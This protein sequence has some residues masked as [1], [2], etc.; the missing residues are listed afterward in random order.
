MALRP[1]K[2][3]LKHGCVNLTREKYCDD[4]KQIEVDKRN[5]YDE[6]RGNRH[7]RGYGYRWSKYSKWYRQQNPLCVKCLAEGKL[8]SSEHV[9]HIIA[10]SGPDDPLFYASSNH[11]AL[12]K[13][14]HSRKTVKEDGGFGNGVH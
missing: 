8:S 9:D 1:Y 13:S 11:Q 12:C 14:C 4:H 7:K 6:R 2:P 10:V 3:C 5:A